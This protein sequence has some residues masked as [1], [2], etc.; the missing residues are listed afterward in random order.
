[1]SSLSKQAWPFR[2]GILLSGRGSNFGAIQEAIES[3][4]LPDTV[5]S[6]VISNHSN[7]LGLQKAQENNLSTAV[8]EKANYESRAALDEAI[9]D[10]LKAHQVDLVVL[11]GYDRIISAPIMAAFEQRILNIH[12]SL[13]PAYGGKGMVGLKVHQAVLAN[14]EKESGCSVH[15]VT[16]QVDEGPVLGQS[17]VPVMPHDTPE[18][19]AAR[20][21]AEEH[22][23][24][25]RVIRQYLQNH[26]NREENQEAHDPVLQ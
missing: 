25:P 8:F 13:L 3:G 7:A 10:C 16:P 11:A 2:L 12:P 22:R 19:L 24:Y 23:L 15:L 14:G 26:L 20:V 4:Q 6:V 1:M 17:R 18:S 21:L 9:A 5:I